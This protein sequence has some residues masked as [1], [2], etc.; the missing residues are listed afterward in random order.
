[1]KWVLSQILDTIRANQVTI[2]HGMTGSGKTT[3]VPQYILDECASDRVYCNIVVTQPRRIAAISIAKR[4]CSERAW[5]LG[6]VCGYQVCT[7]LK[8]LLLLFGWMMLR[9]MA[10]AS[11]C[12]WW[13]EF[14]VVAYGWSFV[15]WLMAGVL[16]CG[17]W[18]ELCVA[19]YGWS[20]MI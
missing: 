2:I 8:P 4:V 9:L 12:C 16:F 6:T 7:L 15:L 13:L 1:M 5:T 11:C 10:G 17:L 20:F 14:C 3:Q 18:L 19:A